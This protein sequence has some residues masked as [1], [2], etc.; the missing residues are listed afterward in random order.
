MAKRDYPVFYCDE[1]E[2][3]FDRGHIRTDVYGRV[4]IKRTGF[5]G[6]CSFV[7]YYTIVVP[8]LSFW[9]FLGGLH[10]KGRRNMRAVKKARRGYFIF[11][12]HAGVKDVTI[13]YL[14]AL[15]NR[16]NTVGYSD[17][18]D[19][20]VLRYLVPALGFIPLPTDP[21]KTPEFVEALRFYLEDRH[22]PVC[23]YPEAHLWP[24]YTG[25]RNFKR[26]SFRYPPYFNVPVVPVFYARRKRKGLWRLLKQ[27]R[28]TCLVGQP[29]YPDPALDNK[30]NA[31]KMGDACYAAL[32]A[33]SQ[34]IPQ[35]DYRH[36]VYRPLHKE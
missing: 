19:G 18:V 9:M 32:L 22:Q 35:E 25:I 12:N 33:L 6:L 30:A 29:I 7:F 20:L 3:D 11:A 24:Q 21:H 28:I 4:V 17:A 1:Q 5:F 23:I 26:A 27:P 2:D 31:Q 34:A 8:A 13:N 10:I 14:L 36:Y 16:L 15:P